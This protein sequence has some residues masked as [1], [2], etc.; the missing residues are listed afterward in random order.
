MV[1]K[2]SL[3]VVVFFIL[4]GNL[5][6]VS[7]EL[8]LTVNPH[9]TIKQPRKYKTVVFRPQTICCGCKQTPYIPS[10]II[11]EGRII[12][13]PGAPPQLSQEFPS[14]S[15]NLQETVF[16]ISPLPPPQ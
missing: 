6:L 14:P 5:Y 2:I 3:I 11:V 9:F 13:C 8:P 12:G 15:T 7:H 16:P 4:V 1:P 10:K